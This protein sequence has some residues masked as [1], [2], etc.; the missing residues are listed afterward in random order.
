[1]HSTEKGCR[2][3]RCEESGRRVRLQTWARS[4]PTAFMDGGLGLMAESLGYRLQ[5]VSIRSLQNRSSSITVNA[6]S[7]ANCGVALMAGFGTSAPVN[8]VHE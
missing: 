4:E 3:E 5:I 6:L 2:N 7:G 8:D 1:M